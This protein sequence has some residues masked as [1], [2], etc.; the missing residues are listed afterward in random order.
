[1]IAQLSFFKVEK[2]HNVAL[3]THII[4]LFGSHLSSS[5]LFF[6]GQRGV[7]TAPLRLT[8]A[9]GAGGGRRQARQRGPQDLLSPALL[10]EMLVVLQLVGRMLRLPGERGMKR[11][12]FG[13]TFRAVKLCCGRKADKRG[14]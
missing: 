2:Q 11:L 7:D 5:P 1:M 13:R 12:V 4:Y 3:N 10:P 9:A 14:R 8:A 6:Q